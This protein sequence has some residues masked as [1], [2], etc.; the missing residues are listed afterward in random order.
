MNSIVQKYFTAFSKKDLSTLSELY[1]EDVVLWEW[2]QRVFMGKQ[3][4]LTA[5]EE[6][7]KSSEQLAV[8]VQ[9][10]AESDDKFYVELGIMLDDR[11]VSVLDV[12]TL[13]NDKIVSVQAYRG[14]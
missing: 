11:V 13:K 2:G 3:E 12:I 9:G 4:V 6:L 8:L 10:Y 1:G 7:F 5:N 14:F